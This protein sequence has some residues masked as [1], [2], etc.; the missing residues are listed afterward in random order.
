MTSLNCSSHQRGTVLFITLILL[1][2]GMLLGVTMS[3]LSRSNLQIVR[4]DQSEQ[5]RASV[6]QGAV[7]QVLN[8]VTSFT[9]PTAPITVANTNGMQVT[10]SDRVCVRQST[11]GGYSAVTG[12]LPPIDTVWSFSVTVTDPMTGGSTVM[13]QG[14]RLRMLVGSCI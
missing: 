6:A 12:G 2:A 13:T 14:T 4:N 8:D 11:A 7:E 10:V 9:S 1:V 3:M 5:Q